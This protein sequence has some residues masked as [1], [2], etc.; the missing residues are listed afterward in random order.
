MSQKSNLP[1]NLTQLAIDVRVDNYSPEVNYYIGINFYKKLSNW[2][3]IGYDNSYNTFTNK[4]TNNVSLNVSRNLAYEPELQYTSNSKD[5]VNNYE[6]EIER[7][8]DNLKLMSIS[9]DISKDNIK[10]L[11]NHYYN[12]PDPE[13]LLALVN[14]KIRYLETKRS[15]YGLSLT[16]ITRTMQLQSYLDDLFSNN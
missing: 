3:T 12:S 16:V 8:F 2:L 15:K 11:T 9:E 10:D 13:I 14:E 7:Y 6:M 4:F 5:N 1:L